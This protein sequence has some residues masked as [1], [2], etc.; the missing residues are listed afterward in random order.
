M[1]DYLRA[2]DRVLERFKGLH[3]KGI[4]LSLDRMQR[5]CAALGDPQ[6]RLPPVVHVAGTNGKG[7]TIAL[8]RGIAEAAGLSV[9]VFT[10]P[11]LVRFAERI[12]LA[13]RLIDDD[14]LAVLLDRV[15]AANGGEPITFFEITTAAVFLA[16]AEAPA[17]LCLI[18]VGL[19]GRFD[20]TNVVEGVVLSV[21]AP[22]DYDHKE[23]LGESLEAIA[24]EKA[25]ILRA[26]VPA[27]IEARAE[28]LNTSLIEAGREFDMWGS[29]GRLTVQAGDQLYDL[30]PPGL[31]GGHQIENAGVAVAAALALRHPAL[32]DE[33]VLAEG[34]SRASWPGRLQRLTRG[35]LG[36]AAQAAG[37]DLWVDGAHNP[38]GAAALADFAAALRA[39]DGRPVTLVVGLL[40]N[41]D[42]G[43]VFRAL[44]PGADRVIAIGFDA[45]AAA[46][47]EVLAQ[48]ARGA[49]IPAEAAPDVTDG[50]RRALAIDG[51][52][53]HLIVCG[54]LYL[55]GEALSL[56]EETW[57]R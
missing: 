41:K 21:I 30:P 37:A 33:S 19:G 34:I 13:G 26:G 1:S 35:P 12:R 14:Q 11:H 18:E 40:V 57:P 15:E 9:H 48:A 7:S 44:A 24:F 22:V 50:V 27:V 39:R 4:D 36:E 32:A 3:K 25:G 51:P 56:S 16:F 31:A 49:G 45:E 8:L 47:P 52:P 10:S 46:P 43:E 54:S 29:A 28:A 38:H 20:C 6:K 53:P 2:H 5:L 23:F 55:V 42:A 17:D